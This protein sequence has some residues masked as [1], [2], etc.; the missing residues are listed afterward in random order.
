MIDA[1][2]PAV[3]EDQLLIQTGAAV[4]CTSDLNDIRENPFG[5]ALPVIMGHEAAGTVVQVGPKA[6]GL[7]VGDRVATHPVHPCGQCVNCRDGVGHLCLNMGHFGL[8]MQGTFAEYF[9]V[10]QDRARKIPA[11]VPFATAALAEPVSVCLEGLSQA[12]LQVG[13]SLLIIGDGPF[14]VLTALLAGKGKLSGLVIAGHH[15]WRMAFAPAAQKVNIKGLADPSEALLAANG[16]RK[17]DAIFLGV[18]RVEAVRQGLALLK[19]KGRLVVFSAIPQPTPV[20]LFSLHCQE[21]EIVGSC[22]DQGRLDEA[23]G[24]LSDASIGLGGLV[25]HRFPIER[26]QEAFN[27]AANGHAKAMKVAL[28]FAQEA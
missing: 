21:L 4:I 7:A 2:V 20:D 22:N 18:G 15:D 23:V 14:G 17:Y 25:T 16:G 8:N 3:G 26:H 24:M 19:P 6:K 5:I 28:T 13:Q 10:R 27:L 9:L 12:R 1:P 11:G